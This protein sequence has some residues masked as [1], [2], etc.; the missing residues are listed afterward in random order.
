MSF[1]EDLGVRTS[2]VVLVV[3]VK[4]KRWE[5]ETG[6]VLTGGESMACQCKQPSLIPIVKYCAGRRYFELEIPFIK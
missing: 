6:G 5:A 2:T 4:V 1:R 3:R